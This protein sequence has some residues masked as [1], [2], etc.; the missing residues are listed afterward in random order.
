[1]QRGQ[2]VVKN[3]QDRYVAVSCGRLRPRVNLES[4][5]IRFRFHLPPFWYGWR[6][7]SRLRR[8]VGPFRAHLSP[9][10]VQ[11]ASEIVFAAPSGA[12]MAPLVDLYRFFMVSVALGQVPGAV[13]AAEGMTPLGLW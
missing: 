7:K 9:I 1:M 2:S 4:P 6:Q 12:P 10:L 11:M 5:L 13:P 8:P 3:A